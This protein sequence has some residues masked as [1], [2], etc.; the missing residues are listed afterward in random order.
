MPATQIPFRDVQDTAKLLALL[1]TKTE[2]E[3]VNIG[4]I[5]EAAVYVAEHYEKGAALVAKH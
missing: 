4:Y 1:R 3:V 5:V 2:S